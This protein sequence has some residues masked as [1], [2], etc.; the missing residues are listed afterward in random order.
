MTIRLIANGITGVSPEAKR[1]YAGLI[2]VDLML[3]DGVTTVWLA[4]QRTAQ[5]L[6]RSFQSGRAGDLTLP[7]P[8]SALEL[9]ALD[10]LIAR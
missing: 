9:A 4:I 7:A 5:T 8:P 6:A 3:D 10:G 2:A 1:A